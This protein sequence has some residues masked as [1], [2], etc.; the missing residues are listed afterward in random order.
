MSTVVLTGDPL[1]AGDVV[2]VARR[3]S[4]VELGPG[5][6]DRMAGARRVVEE[7]VAGDAIVYGITTQGFC[8]PS[9]FWPISWTS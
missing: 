1:Q 5:V 7:A 4:A 3:D 9:A 8:A 6:A 2:A